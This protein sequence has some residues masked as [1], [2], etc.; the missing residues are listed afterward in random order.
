MPSN[1]AA[2]A[3]ENAFTRKRTTRKT[4]TENSMGDAHINVASLSQ[5]RRLVLNNHFKLTSSQIRYLIWLLRLSREGFGVKNVELATALEYSKP[6][7]HNMLKSLAK[8]GVVSP[9]KTFGLVHLTDEGRVLAKKY[10]VCFELLQNK[11]NELC[12]NNATTEI[13]ICG[14]LADMPSNKID[15]LYETGKAVPV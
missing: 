9:Q 3:V 2:S 1:A 14:I 11:M 12:G 8:I 5:K 7:V 15:E 4:T 6:S 13:A 10:E